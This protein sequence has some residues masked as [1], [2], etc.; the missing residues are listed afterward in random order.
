MVK[1][2]FNQLLAQYKSGDL[3]VLLL[4]LVLAV[5][6]ITAVNFF[7]YR[8]AAH[9]NSQGGLLLGGDLALISDHAIS[10]HVVEAAKHQ[11]LNTTQTLEFAS[12]AIVGEKNRLAEIKAL[13]AGFPL[14]GNL[15]VKLSENAP[16]QSVQTIPNKN[17]VWIEPR[18]AD[19]LK[20]KVG[21]K[22]ELGASQLT[23][24]ALL[25]REPSRGGDMFSFAPRLMMNMDDVAATQLVQFGSRVKYQVLVAGQPVNVARFATD[26]TPKLQRGEHVEDVK[27][28]RPEIKSALDKAEIFLNLSALVSVIL[29]IVAMLL[30][31]QPF[32]TRAQ[33]TAGLLRCFGA[34]TA[35]IQAVMIW[36]VLLLATI[37]GVIGC[38]LG[39]LLQQ[40]LAYFAGQLFLENLPQGSIK[41]FFIGMGLSVSLLWALLLPH[42]WALKTLPTSRILRQDLTITAASIWARILP[43]SVVII[44]LILLLAKSF[45]LAAL[46]LAGIIGIST[47]T[48]LLAF[49]L[50][51]LL[52]KTSFTNINISQ[53]IRFGLANLNRRL[54]LSITQIIGFSLG[55]MVLILLMLLKNDLLSAWQNSMP[56]NAP[57]RFVINIQSN[58][59]SDLKAFELNNGINHAQVFPMI[60]GRLTAINHKA[61]TPEYFASERAK[62]LVAR[63]F[64]LSSAS[65]LQEDNKLLQ[66]RWWRADEASK[67][68][69]SIEE[70]IADA[71]NIKLNDVLEYDIAGSKISLTVTS[72]RKVN[73]DSMRANFF[74]V[75]PAETLKN[76]PS[77]FMT[78]FYLPKQNDNNLN[79]L[80]QQFPNFT[81]IDV[82]SLMLQ[83][84]E[85]MQKMQM[86]VSVVFGFCMVA[87]LA[88]LYAALIATRGARIQESALLRV[89]G[90]SKAQMTMSILTEFACIGAVAAI[91]ATAFASGLAYYL[92]RFV[93]DIAYQFNWVLAA[94]SLMLAFILVPLAAWLVI[95]SYLNVP[96]KQLLNSI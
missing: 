32:V 70:S 73:W 29:S 45:K 5:S 93:L 80:I 33:E 47:L 66:G 37:G 7:T 74:A 72:I 22:I 15:E 44:G 19:A 43:L 75:T 13:G 23:V 56:I 28:A 25:T 3:R 60:R 35:N 95:R 53:S 36:Q 9:L 51:K 8:I 86:A 16:T 65:R 54:G 49:L 20:I 64:N 17:E 24:A 1:L 55:A 12:M 61:V 26:I 62:R 11:S 21:D 14:R 92:S 58:Q 46:F 82:A 91:V 68:Y 69:L 2:A 59:V 42:I 18:L 41:P 84:R 30:A 50:A 57:N 40:S 79:K 4:A 94:K 90:A 63:E 31:C 81:V 96:P 27:T 89:L 38:A 77:S 83:V 78:A 48:G 76:Y 88:V 6:S 67:P 39:Y 71:L 52:L 87:G 34:S 85:V 10:N